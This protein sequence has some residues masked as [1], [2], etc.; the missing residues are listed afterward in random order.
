MG[1]SVD[2]MVEFVPNKYWDFYVN[3]IMYTTKFGDKGAIYLGGMPNYLY[4][5]DMALK[6]GMSEQQAIQEASKSCQLEHDR[7]KSPKQK[8]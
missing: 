7:C 3:F 1:D 5:K 4:Y 8:P 6:R 2:D